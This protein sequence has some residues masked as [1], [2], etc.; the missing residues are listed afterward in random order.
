MRSRNRDRVKQILD[1]LPEPATRLLRQHGVDSPDGWSE[2]D[3]IGLPR[4]V[5][6]FVNDDSNHCL[7]L[8]IATNDAGA[9]RIRREAHGRAWAA[10]NGIETAELHGFGGRGQWSLGEWIPPQPAAGPDPRWPHWDAYLDGATKAIGQIE[11]ATPSRPGPPS[12]TWRSPRR[13]KLARAARGVIARRGSANSRATRSPG[14]PTP[15]A[16]T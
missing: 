3:G 11:A 16:P 9:L 8:E 4:P 12:A 10:E 14:F 15:T 2:Q 6:R 1:E 7:V 5:R 13:K